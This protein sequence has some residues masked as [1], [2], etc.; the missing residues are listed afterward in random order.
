MN[1]MPERQSESALLQV[2]DL[3]V[4]YGKVEALHRV[5][6][7]VEDGLIVTVIGPTRR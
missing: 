1:A 4:A 7:V 6:L 2:R 3:S 5:N